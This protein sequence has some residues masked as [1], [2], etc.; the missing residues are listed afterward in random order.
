MSILLSFGI[1]GFSVRSVRCLF[2]V[3]SFCSDEFRALVSEYQMYVGLIFQCHD[4]YFTCSFFLRCKHVSTSAVYP[5]VSS[6]IF[7][8]TR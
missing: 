7:P 5:A 2:L 3:I 6:H 8:A 4:I 1:F